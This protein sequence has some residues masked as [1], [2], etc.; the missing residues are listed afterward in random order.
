M[1][2][3]RGKELSLNFIRVLAVFLSLGFFATFLPFMCYPLAVIVLGVT[4]I[5]LVIHLAPFP[6]LLNRLGD[7]SYGIYLVHLPLVYC[8]Y[9]LVRE[10]S[11]GFIPM[12]ALMIVVVLPLA[13]LNGKLEYWMYRHKI[14]PLVDRWLSPDRP[15][16]STRTMESQ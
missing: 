1:P 6:S 2:L 11:P 3:E 9:L 13:V 5:M 8:L 7:Y 16:S 10:T 15:S 14:R 12:V 4:S